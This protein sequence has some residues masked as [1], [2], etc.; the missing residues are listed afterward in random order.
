VAAAALPLLALA[1]A[2]DGLAGA[3][4]REPD[5]VVLLGQVAD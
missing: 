4:S 3:L 5:A 1:I 2:I